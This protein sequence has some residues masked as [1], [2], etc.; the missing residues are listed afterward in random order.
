MKKTSRTSMKGVSLEFK[1]EAIARR[2]AAERAA[3]RR[4]RVLLLS[5]ALLA[6]A[7]LLW[8]LVPSCEAEPEAEPAQP[9]VAAPTAQ[10]EPPEPPEPLA[11][12]PAQPRPT[13]E[14][15]DPE[16]LPW[17]GELRMQV[18]ARSPRL[19][20]CFEGAERPGR[21]KWSAS[22]EPKHGLA[23]EHRIEPTLQ[24][25][26]LTEEQRLCVILVLSDPPYKLSSD[27]RGAPSR[28][29]MVI[30]F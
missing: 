2:L 25:D 20:A 26:E 21:L 1:R 9:L 17:I 18:A 3:V 24:S 8:L 16:P 27:D 5:L 7:L 6:L 14:V 22:V 19:A 30:E 4:R 23:S 28:V 11:R 29:S 15:P 12:A 10:P 13:F